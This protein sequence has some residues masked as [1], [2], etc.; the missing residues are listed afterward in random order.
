MQN[1]ARHRHLFVRKK[2]YTLGLE[3]AFVIGTLVCVVGAMPHPTSATFFLESFTP[4][5]LRNI[6]VCCCAAVKNKENRA[7]LRKIDCAGKENAGKGLASMESSAGK[8]L[9]SSS[10]IKTPRKELRTTSPQGAG[11]KGSATS[12]GQKDNFF[13][14]TKVF[15]KCQHDRLSLSCMHEKNGYAAVT[16]TTKK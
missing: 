1:L 8:P 13:C 11:M 15:S 14:G 4:K 6:A 12:E 5:H 2:E 9:T 16:I 3:I 10:T 7:K